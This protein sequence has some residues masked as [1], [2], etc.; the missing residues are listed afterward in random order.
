MVNR[1]IFKASSHSLVYLPVGF[2]HPGAI[3]SF[4]AGL[5]KIRWNLWS[6]LLIGVIT[7]LQAG[8]LLLMG[9]TDNIWVCYAAYTLFRGFYQF[10]VPIAM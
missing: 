1:N 5:V 6:E 2:F 4:L 9:L 3:T 8:L 10:L 7:A